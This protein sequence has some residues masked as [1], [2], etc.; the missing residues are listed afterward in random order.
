MRSG[1]T[2]CQGSWTKRG[3]E[4]SHARFAVPR[5]FIRIPCSRQ[6]QNIPEFAQYHRPRTQCPLG[7]GFAFC[8]S[9]LAFRA[10]REIPDCSGRSR[11]DYQLVP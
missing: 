7:N 8:V 6:R 9:W 1:L 4:L 5:A 2:Y 3:L 10:G 11:E